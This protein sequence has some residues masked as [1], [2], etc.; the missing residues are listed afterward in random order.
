MKRAGW[1]VAAL[2]AVA[3]SIVSL[4]Y[5]VIPDSVP[6]LKLQAGWRRFPFL[7]HVA[8]S[9][10]ALLVG[11]LQFSSRLRARSLASHRL[12]GRLYMAGIGLGGVSGLIL[13]FYTAGGLPA[14]TGFGMLAVLW[15]A[16]GFM[17]WR[18]ILRRDI[19]GH[20]EWMIRN[21]ALTFAAVTLRL[22]WPSLQK[23]GAGFEESYQTVAWLCWVPNLIVAELATWRSREA[24]KT[25]VD[26]VN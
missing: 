20:R 3:V 8:A 13:A 21:F 22:W 4:R 17:A 11:P 12:I 24:D 9:A 10:F 25:G 19:P 1:I 6:L 5:F 7:T 14:R 15:L 18:Q 23:L 16:T 2:L 26:P